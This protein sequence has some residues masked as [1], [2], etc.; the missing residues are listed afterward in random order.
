VSAR[1]NTPG[2]HRARLPVVQDGPVHKSVASNPQQVADIV[3]PRSWT[4]QNPD[5]LLLQYL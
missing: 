3:A 4:P 2:E 5:E 1:D